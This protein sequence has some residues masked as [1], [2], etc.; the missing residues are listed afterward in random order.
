[1][2][3]QSYKQHTEPTTARNPRLNRCTSTTSYGFMQMVMCFRCCMLT[4]LVDDDEMTARNRVPDLLV[5]WRLRHA[6]VCEYRVYSKLYVYWLLLLATK[7]NI[8]SSYGDTANTHTH[9]ITYINKHAYL[10]ATLAVSV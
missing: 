6:F 5:D 9:K 1:M 2:F 4:M 8:A 10:H 3:H 7:C